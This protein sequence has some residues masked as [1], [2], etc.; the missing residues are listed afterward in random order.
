MLTKIENLKLLKIRKE[1]YKM[2]KFEI[3]KCPKCE[4]E[5]Y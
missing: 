4:N 2:V 5:R 3:I 1:S